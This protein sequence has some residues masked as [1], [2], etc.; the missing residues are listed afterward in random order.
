M[1]VLFVGAHPDDIE[2]GAGGTLMKHLKRGDSIVYIVISR[3]EKGCTYSD[4]CDR[5]RELLNVISSLR[6]ES[7]HIHGFPDTRLHEH[8]SDIKNILE[9]IVSKTGPDRVYT[10]SLNDSH[11]DHI[12]VARATMIACRR[13]PQV[14]SYWSPSS[15]NEFRPSYFIDITDVIEEKIKLLENYMSQGRKDYLKRELVRAVNKYM[16]FLAGSDF[17]EGFEVVRYLEL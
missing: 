13:V 8:F 3:G 9:N 6:L 5:I 12:A 1:I 14:L 16:G 15:Y 17:A 4:S 10:H 7:F 11:Q 2:I